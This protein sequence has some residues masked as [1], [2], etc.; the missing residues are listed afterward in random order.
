MAFSIMTVNIMT[1]RLAT[2][3]RIETLDNDA[4]HDS[5]NNEGKHNDIL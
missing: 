5:K 4:K 3:H 2:H 1:P